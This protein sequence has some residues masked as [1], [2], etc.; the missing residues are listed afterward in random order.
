MRSLSTSAF[1]HPSETKEMRGAG[2]AGAAGGL[3][4]AMPCHRADGGGK[5]AAAT[6]S[7]QAGPGDGSRVNAKL[8]VRRARRP[9]GVALSLA[10]WR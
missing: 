2:L 4:M 6:M 3:V 7:P 1:G 10:Q 8:I 5:A 9:D